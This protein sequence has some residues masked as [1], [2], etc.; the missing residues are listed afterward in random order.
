MKTKRKIVK[1]KP[2]NTYQVYKKYIILK[3]NTLFVS[4]TKFIH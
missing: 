2:K 1:K 3:K 4:L